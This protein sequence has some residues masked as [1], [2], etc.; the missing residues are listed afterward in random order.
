MQVFRKPFVDDNFVSTHVARNKGGIGGSDHRV[1]SGL[2]T[3]LNEVGE[4]CQEADVV[5]EV[6]RGKLIG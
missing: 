5:S 3:R 2:V 6:G 4:I 1:G